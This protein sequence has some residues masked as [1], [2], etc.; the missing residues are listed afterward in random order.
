M[1][2]LPQNLIILRKY[3]GF[4]VSDFAEKL[5]IQY[6]TYQSYERGERKPPLELLEQLVYKY[7]V[8]MNW[9]LT[10]EGEMFSSSVQPVAD[11]PDV[12]TFWNKKM[13]DLISERLKKIREQIN[14]NASAFARQLN[15]LQ[16]T[17]VKYERGERKPP[18]ELL[19]QLVLKYGVNRNW[20]LTG[21]GEM[22]S[23]SNP[24]SPE[25]FEIPV[26]GDVKASMGYG[27]T[28]FEQN[29]T[30]IY[31]VSR[32][33]AEDLNL[34]I[35]KTEMIFASGDSMAP[36]IEG[37]DSLLIDRS[38]TEIHD[39]KIYCVRINGELYAKRL[40]FVPPS[41]VV[42]ISD[43]RKYKSFDVDLSKEINY[44]FEIIGEVRWW[45]RVSR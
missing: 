25:C 17:Y 1:L 15:I 27:V 33:L 10:G 11:S 19:E 35:K 34:N 37:G 29:R 26:L 45:G 9:L 12:N 22:F 14:P 40:Q 16:T 7:G 28:V 3:L 6:R 20:L 41:T 36:T 31:P 43:N 18:L 23:S 38:K 39:G 2:Q 42:V 5:G 4:K 30:G 21:E 8:N 13:N 24:S 32:Q 44:D